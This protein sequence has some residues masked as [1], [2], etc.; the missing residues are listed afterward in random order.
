MN[1]SH[2]EAQWTGSGYIGLFSPY[3]STRPQKVT[4]AQGNIRLFHDRIYAEC[5]AWRALQAAEERIEAL[6]FGPGQISLPAKPK[7]FAGKRALAQSVFRE[8]AEA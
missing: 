7:S 6:R 1:R 3:W 4:D 8:R 5:H 2:A